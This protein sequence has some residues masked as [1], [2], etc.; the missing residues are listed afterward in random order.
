MDSI[1]DIQDLSKRFGGKTV[2]DQRTGDT[3]RGIAVRDYERAGGEAVVVAARRRTHTR[4]V[5]S[6][7]LAVFQKSRL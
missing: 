6:Q 3:G 7:P 5:Q 1:I 4:F 2:V